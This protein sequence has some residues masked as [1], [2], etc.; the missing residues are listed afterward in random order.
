M[1]D[2]VAVFGEVVEEGAPDFGG[3][4]GGVMLHL[5]LLSLLAGFLR[6]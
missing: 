5:G 2:F 3:G 1:D 6:N 4:L